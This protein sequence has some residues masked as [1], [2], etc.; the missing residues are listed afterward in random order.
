MSLLEPAKAAV[1]VFVASILQVTIFSGVEIL[2]GT[3]DVVL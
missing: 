2:G 3:P 1:L